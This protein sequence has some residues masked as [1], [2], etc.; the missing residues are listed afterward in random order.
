MDNFGIPQAPPELHVWPPDVQVPLPDIWQ[1]HRVEVTD[2]PVSQQVACKADLRTIEDFRR[3]QLPDE[4]YLREMLRWN[5]THDESITTFV[6]HFGFL[7]WQPGLE[8][9]PIERLGHW[10]WNALRS[11]GRA[12]SFY[13][14]N[15]QQ[16]HEFGAQDWFELFD[17]IRL[18][19]IWLSDLARMWLAYSFTGEFINAAPSWESEWLGI[20]CPTS[21]EEAREA[22]ASGLSAALRPVSFHI[23]L[24]PSRPVTPETRA[25]L[26]FGFPSVYSIIA[27]QL[28]NHVVERPQFRVC[29]NKTCGPPPQVFVR[30]VRGGRAKGSDK[31]WSPHTKG[32][33]YCSRRCA[34]AQARRQWREDQKK[35]AEER[36]KG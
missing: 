21:E 26:D 24:E 5:L 18:G 23:A 17:E 19:L 22:F 28:Y 27:I 7:F 35:K 8:T 13:I 9:P 10:A 14:P 34:Q 32:V 29:E 30:Q 25:T 20:A 36:T 1:P 15:R 6:S 12:E 33:K 31:G 16:V 4:F 11:S 2:D 3:V